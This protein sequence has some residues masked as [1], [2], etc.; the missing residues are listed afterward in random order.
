MIT[1]DFWEISGSESLPI[2]ENFGEHKFLKYPFSGLLENDFWSVSASVPITSSGREYLRTI[3]IDWL[4]WGI[5]QLISIK[6]RV[7]KTITVAQYQWHILA[8]RAP[9]TWSC[10]TFSNVHFDGQSYTLITNNIHK[11][12]P[13]EIKVNLLTSHR[14]AA[15][16][17]TER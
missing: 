15:E 5:D 2:L 4:L 1:P 10:D 3:R 8:C 9:D 6:L 16:V 13:E 12:R 14:P 17:C 7:N 11:P